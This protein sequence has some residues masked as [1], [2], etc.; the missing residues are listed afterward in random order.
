V[1]A[2]TTANKLKFPPPAKT[3]SAPRSDAKANSAAPKDEAPAEE[4]IPL[5]DA[6]AL[7]SE[8]PRFELKGFVNPKNKCFLNVTLQALLACM[9][10]S[11]LLLKLDK[12]ILPDRAKT[13]KKF[14]R[15]RK[16]FK[17]IEANAPAPLVNAPALNPTAFHALLKKFNPKFEHA[18]SYQE[19]AHE[20]LSFILNH[21]HDEFCHILRTQQKQ[22]S[23]KS[24]EDDGEWVEVG[25]ANKTAVIVTKEKQFMESPI[26]DI[27]GG[28]LRSSLKR[29]NSKASVSLQPFFTLH[30]D[31]REDHITNIEDALHYMTEKE[32]VDGVTDSRTQSEVSASKE[33]LIEKLPKILILHLKRFS[34]SSGTQKISKHIEFPINL[35]LKPNLFGKTIANR[36]YRIL[37]VISHLGKTAANGHYTCD[38][39]VKG[40]TFV[41]YDDARY[42]SV[43]Q[44]EVL[45]S[46]AYLL[47][48][49]LLPK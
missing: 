33:N 2:W 12:A 7:P 19:D 8:N 49:E 44:T 17:I 38:I 46:E 40:G 15:L 13:L 30:L 43:K 29:P 16:E 23:G 42:F 32:H 48:Y 34:F 45:E 28:V 5:A 37:S 24:E 36:S 10:L 4:R 22:E 18:H 9:P 1:P 3:T 11:Q 39:R 6:L 25:K 31:I 47:F 14:V 41:R 27:F 35:N 26:T 20:F 21:M